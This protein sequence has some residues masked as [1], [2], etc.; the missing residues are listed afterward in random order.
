MRGT[1]IALAGVF[2][3]ALALFHI[4]FWRLFGW[5]ASLAGSGRLNVAITQTLNIVLTY[6][7]VVYGVALLWLGTATPDALL[8]AAAGFGV[9]RI[10][11]QFLLFRVESRLAVLFTGL[12][13]AGTLLHLIPP[14]IGR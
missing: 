10:A 12:M 8:L 4:L 7:F 3:L 14:V 9:L 6:V 11:L 2:D 1:L 5:P 13:V